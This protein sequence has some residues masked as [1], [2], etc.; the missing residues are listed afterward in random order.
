MSIKERL[1][2]FHDAYCRWLADNWKNRWG[3]RYKVFDHV[4]VSDASG[5]PIKQF[6]DRFFITSPTCELLMYFQEGIDWEESVKRRII[7]SLNLDEKGFDIYVEDTMY[8]GDREIKYGAHP[9]YVHPDYSFIIE[10]KHTTFRPREIREIMWRQDALIQRVEGWENP[11]AGILPEPAYRYGVWGTWIMQ[12]V[13]YM[14]HPKL[15]LDPDSVYILS[16]RG[17]KVE[18]GSLSKMGFTETDLGW[19]IDRYNERLNAV[20]QK[21]S[22]YQGK[23]WI[24]FNLEMIDTRD[25]AALWNIIVADPGH[26]RLTSFK[27]RH[28]PY[29]WE[30][31]CPGLIPLRTFREWRPEE[32]QI[33]HKLA[34]IPDVKAVLEF[35]ND[36]WKLI[37][38]FNYEGA[39]RTLQ[40]MPRSF[41]F[42]ILD[43][44]IR[45][46]DKVWVQ[47]FKRGMFG[48]RFDRAMTEEEIEELRE[49]IE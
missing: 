40:D 20:A 11:K 46:R 28:C 5:C 29:L 14:T 36:A 21:I 7:E 25:I 1:G 44:F 42:Q 6:L 4:Y 48:V 22:K 2:E 39:L 30:G 31:T 18:M 10:I 41:I 12:A 24:G 49:R 13:G 19:F 26:Y 45:N 47:P 35:A 32:I 37:L 33:L 23:R 3:N 9:D 27:C 38:Q 16:N 43:A 8:M 34:V 15:N 17:G